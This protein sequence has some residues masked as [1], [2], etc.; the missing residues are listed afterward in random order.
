MVT[1]PSNQ[2]R[3]DRLLKLFRNVTKGGKSIATAAE[4]RLF[5]E[6]VRTHTSPVECLESVTATEAAKEAFRHSIRIDTSVLFIRSDVLP[7]LDYLGDPAIKMV[8]NGQLLS[9]VLGIIVHPPFLWESLL[10]AYADGKFD[11][12][13]LRTFAWLC[14]ELASLPQT[15]DSII[16]GIS[17]ALQQTPLQETQDHATRDV[18]YRIKK[19]LALRSL[20][21]PDKDADAAGGRHDNDFANF[22][23]IS[24]FPTSDEFYSS[25][26]PYFRRAAEVDATEHAERPRAHL[27]N[28][29]RLLREDM[30]GELRDDLKVAIGRKKSR[31]NT[32]QIL[33]HLAPVGMDTGDDRRGRFCTVL[34][35]CKS[36]LESL[37]QLSQASRGQYL[38]DH[39]SFLRHQS[40]GALCGDKHIVAFAF[41]M[42]DVDQLV[43]EPPV[44]ALQFT[45]SEAFARALH[46]LQS[47]NNLR[48]ILV[49]T[50][51][52]AYQPVLE[53]LQGM[54]EMP[55]DG[56]LL[57]DDSEY[58]SQVVYSTQIK[59]CVD[60][61]EYMLA[62]DVKT[63]RIGRQTFELDESQIRA[64]LH[65]LKSPVA[66]IQGPPGTGKSFVGALVAKILLSD[67]DKRVLVL[68]YTNHALDQ[69]LEDLTKIGILSDSMVR[70]GSKYNQV[71]EALSLDKLLRSEG[72]QQTRP[73]W[74][75]INGAKAVM[76]EV[77]AEI[78][79]ACK[80]LMREKALPLEVFNYLEFLDDAQ[81]FYEAFRLPEQEDGF[82]MVGSEG[83]PQHKM[84][85]DYL[86]QRWARG[87][88][89]GNLSAVL[90][91]ESEYIW[92]MT[93]DERSQHL[94]TWVEQLRREQIETI[95]R[96]AQRYDSAQREVDTLFDESK[97]A[98]VQTKRLI[99]CTTTA[100]AKYKSLVKAA[101]P[102]VVLVEEAGEILEAH[103]L[104]ALHSATSQ[105]ILIGDHKQLRPKINNYALS[106]E[107]GDGYDLN[108]SLFERLILQ[109]QDHITL[110]KQHRMHP[111]I[112]DLVRE[113]TYPQ[114]LDDEK[115]LLRATPR[116]LG[117][118][119]TFINH[120][121]P[122]DLACEIADRGD[123]GFKASKKNRYEA[124]MVL[125]I[126]KYLGQQ[127]YKTDN[128]VVLTPYLGQL[129][130]LKELL[131][132][133]NDP[134]L[135]DMDSFELI[136][137]GLM[138]AAAGKVKHGSGQ[139]KLST[140]DN[141]QGE[142]S[143]IVIASMTRSNTR[144]DIGFM[145]A[146]ER[147]NVLCSRARECLILVGN[148][149]TFMGSLQGKA[150][151]L[152]FFSL[153]KEK[154]YLHDG[155]IVRCQQHPEKTALLTKPEDF[156]SKC[157]DGGC[158]KK[159]DALLSCEKHRCQMRCHRIADHSKTACHEQVQQTCDRGQVFTLRC[160]EQDVICPTCHQEDEDNRRRMK[161]DLQ[162]EKDRLLAQKR[163]AEELQRMQD[164]LD[165]ERRKLKYAQEED[166]QKRQLEQA[167]A[168]LKDIRETRTLAEA[169]RE[170][171]KVN[172]QAP[173]FASAHED[174]CTDDFLT[175]SGARAEWE[176]M[177]KQFGASSAPLDTLMG[178][179]GLESVKEEFLSI[180]SKV[181]VAVRQ[182]ASLSKQRFGC[183][184]LGN[185]GTGKTTV[186]RI[187]G[188]FLRSV[189]VIAGAKFEETS[190]SR[191]ANEGVS[192]C[193]AM[194]EK[195]LND[196]GGVVFID[197]AYQLSSGNSRGGSAV[198]DFLLAEVENL[199]GRIVFV[200]AGYNKQMESF[201]AHNPGFPSRF[202]L[203]MKFADYSDS[204]LLK[205]M[206]ME[207]KKTYGGRMR[208]EDDLFMRIAIR[209]LGRGR[210]K[211]G[212]GNARAVQNLLDRVTG[213]QA[214]RLRKERLAK[215]RSDDLLL[216]K[217]DLIGP[218]PSSALGKSEAW[219]S[220]LKLIGLA[221]VK[222][223]V[224][225]LVDSL[226]TNYWRELAEEP[227]LEYTLNK[228]FLGSPGTGKT[229]VAKL[230]G[231][232]LVDIGL[233]SNG[234]VIVKNPSDFVGDVIGG[235][236][237]QTKGILASTMGK[238]LVIDEAYGLYDGG[239]ASDLRGTDPFRA[240]VV[241]TI[242]AEVQS[243][244]GED[245][246]VLLL[247]YKDQ[248]EKMFQN[249]NPGLSRRFPMESAFTF[250]DF[251]QS[252]LQ[253]I[254]EIKLKQSG[255]KATDQAKR[256]ALE[257]LDRTRNRPNFGN[258]GEVDILLD[259]AK[260]RH[261]KRL[262][263]NQ[264]DRVSTLEALDFDEDF[265]RAERAD[266][267]VVKL[268][269]GTLGCE[270]IVAKLEGFQESVRSMKALGMD[271]KDH[272]PFNF[273]FRGP[274]GTGKTSTARKMGKVF[275]DMGFLSKAEVLDCSATDLIGSYV[276]HT[277]PKVQKLLDKAL[278]R[279]LF[280]DE[281]YRL[282]G[283]RFAQEAIDELVDCMT[284][285]RYK[286]R[287]I[288]I[289]AGY[290]R[291]MSRLLSVNQGL[292]SR[293]QEVFDFPSLEP[294]DCFKLLVQLLQKQKLKAESGKPT[295]SMLLACLDNPTTQFRGD[296]VNNFAR[297]TE[298]DGWGSARDVELLAKLV[299]K[300]ALKA[301]QGPCI[302]I[303]EDIVR[304]EMT[305]M[306]DERK[307]RKPHPKPQQTV[308]EELQN[309]AAPPTLRPSKMA[310]GTATSQQPQVKT[311]D[312]GQ[313]K[314]ADDSTRRGDDGSIRQVTRDAGVSDEDWEQLER[315]KKTEEEKQRKYDDLRK[316]QREASG[317][318]REAILKQLI[319]EEARRQKEEAERKKAEKIGKCPAGYRWI[320][321]AG[322]YRCAGG[323]HYV[324][325]EQIGR[326]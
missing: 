159:C 64:V 229:T 311:P 150:V 248:M 317:A 320:K 306:F 264:T 12:A 221:A 45:N 308:D 324:T 27:D 154:D 114:L 206:H 314:P 251:N 249:A 30:L 298:Q 230:Y 276:G 295:N 131:S 86:F 135:N 19:V 74:E 5:L 37:T 260:V 167:R 56:C 244:P 254:L 61:F 200:L 245:R 294:E 151:W 67:P 216:T 309:L 13:N 218:E 109:D 261:Q 279:V 293:F 262:S 11:E 281:A 26:P 178:M 63:V 66:L 310:T 164:E 253:N 99:G 283:G 15:D 297:L 51:V 122:E 69:F 21:C 199:T 32:P 16:S 227:I 193:K 50:P 326:G 80:A 267:N 256:V 209:R 62:K 138:T 14:F 103:I 95:Q 162:M 104:T 79:S 52:F 46:A 160:S 117:G 213:R 210:G 140:I 76:A 163:Y 24:I 115:T 173:D 184:L 208:W 305:A 220:L 322:G 100:A 252:E 175:L 169:M 312:D 323:S 81:D 118:R 106:V 6:A 188:Q 223:S 1:V 191:L 158:D 233:L 71:T 136:R 139:I 49:D 141:Y 204:E 127:G 39:R 165:H 152:P 325:D 289:L 48:F 68:S 110:Q 296:V 146:P 111:E 134:V 304:K 47:P 307:T 170:A 18:T 112:S 238:V 8:Y 259:Q 239:G 60:Q 243:V 84:G 10:A 123:V 156:G 197:E 73:P 128:I 92:E 161:R 130:L 272:V 196:G 174:T 96:L 57:R 129:R 157:P 277:G 171:S 201:F 302:T 124:E 83:N 268:F 44:I 236:E 183:T 28:Q 234:E 54:V 291:D 132:K 237:K 4:A 292:S 299:F 301:R 313:Q 102:D 41:L 59:T 25:V 321:Q 202:P 219:A 278:G 282:A 222:E 217:E 269:E 55:L 186:G 194:L 246:C 75:K 166:D 53:C 7:F 318:A 207:L 303:T 280:I 240:A 125:K 235:S 90:S 145:K 189:G 168:D 176:D 20:P 120:S 287:L 224:K 72:R 107:K 284:K 147:L 101:K 274:P 286:G 155:L 285:E 315:D 232:I 316:A 98:L 58:P 185:P 119:V 113:M 17:S 195:M 241:D 121:Q 148:M 70:L 3:T 65:A 192:G 144:G 172:Q 29:F 23:D 153:L 93:D 263:S 265:D 97:C 288:I 203:E 87:Q 266:T 226:Q 89:A 34:L 133:E 38:K 108:R 290:E 187:Y 105:V 257:M 242:V 231:A 179:T 88:D 126:V 77:R 181:D 247:G 300:A 255:F 22:R 182:N 78:D 9:Q 36:G 149:E 273:I 35:T 319:E 270:K 137:A 43:K 2:R 180:K 205:I 82:Q 33:G 258:A 116:G 225:A 40:F 94:D 215:V 250:E 275:F 214:D 228:V 198:L 177:K 142:E 91:Q 271:P 143:D 211:E 42:R 212:F 190:G 85:P 31:K